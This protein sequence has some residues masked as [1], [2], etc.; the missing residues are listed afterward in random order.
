MAIDVIKNEMPYGWEKRTAKL[1]GF[2][3]D[4]A[5]DWLV[6]N[7]VTGTT[8]AKQLEGWL[9]L[10]VAQAIES[11]YHSQRSIP[12]VAELVKELKTAADKVADAK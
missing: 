10:Y 8:P 4:N 2:T 5:G 11:Q 6:S 7:Y 3:D 1:L 12:V 9:L